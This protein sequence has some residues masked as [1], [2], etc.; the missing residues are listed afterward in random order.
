MTV[1]ISTYF[2]SKSHI[3][4]FILLQTLLWGTPTSNFEYRSTFDSP[5]I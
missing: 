1:T 4:I 2:C 5:N 3:Y